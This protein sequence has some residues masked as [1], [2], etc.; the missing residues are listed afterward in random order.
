MNWELLKKQEKLLLYGMGNGADKLLDIFSREGIKC[1]GVFASDEF[2]RGQSFR[3]YK[4]MTHG[5]AK[6]KFGSF[7]VVLAFATE[8]PEILERI[9][10][11]SREHVLFCPDL[12][13]FGEGEFTPE[14]FEIKKERIAKARALLTDEKSREAL[15]ALVEYKLSGNIALLQPITTTAEEDEKMLPLDN[16]AFVDLGA[17]DGDTARLFAKAHSD[18]DCIYAFEPDKKNFIKLQRNMDGMRDT[19]IFNLAAWSESASLPF[20]SRAG[21]NSAIGCGKA[22]V[23]ADALDNMLCDRRITYVKLD[24]EGAEREAISG[25]RRIIEKQKPALKVSA[26]HRIDDFFELPIILSELGY[27]NVALRKNP[28]Y[29]A[30]ETIACAWD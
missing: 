18:Y 21:R 19:E 4:V 20:S 23:E 1:D 16:A 14:Y 30:W 11:F 6:E 26:Y 13:V 9:E 8:L 28:Y 27:K 17:Y 2:V 15:D 3:G 29:P 25:M 5:E 22:Y 24:V 12:P 7:A 10:R